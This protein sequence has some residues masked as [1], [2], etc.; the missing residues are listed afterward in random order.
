MS[1]IEHT[2]DEIRH[3]YLSPFR[4]DYIGYMRALIARDVPPKQVVL[5]TLPRKPNE[6]TSRDLPAIERK[7]AS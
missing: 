4:Y 7:T 3:S 5:G 1:E 2:S 6:E